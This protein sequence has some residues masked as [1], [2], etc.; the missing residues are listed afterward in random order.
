MS[1]GGVVSRDGAGQPRQGEAVSTVVPPGLLAARRH[2]AIIHHVPGRV[3]LR[4]GVGLLALVGGAGRAGAAELTELL[5]AVDGIEGVEV[6][7]RAASVTI[8]YDPRRLPSAT[9]ET[10]LEGDD[11]EAAALL[12]SLVPALNTH[13]QTEEG[14]NGND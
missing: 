3:R 12:E 4:L 9:W 13:H 11:H 2:L 6:N 10:L 8:T 7:G 1:P 5:Q 14:A